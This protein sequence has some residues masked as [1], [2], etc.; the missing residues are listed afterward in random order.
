MPFLGHAILDAEMDSAGGPYPLAIFVHGL[1]GGTLS[2]IYLCEHLAS[3]GF[4]VIAIDYADSGDLSTQTDP[5][6]SLFTRPK[7]VS[8]QIDYMG[9]LNV[10]K[11][12]KL[13]GMIDLEHIALIGHSFGG[14]T[15]LVAGGALV[16]LTGPTSWCLKEPNKDLPAE[17]GGGTLQDRF[18]SHAQ[19]VANLADLK[20]VPDGL[21]PSWGDPRIDV[22]VSL[23]P[24]LPYFGAES[25][26]TIT[27]PT[28]LMYGTK[29]HI[30]WTEDTLYQP[31]AY[32]NLSSKTKSLV[33]FDQADHS[34]F[35]TD[36]SS[37][38]WL[39]D[40]GFFWACSDQV[41]DMDRAHD[42]INHFTTAY[43]LDQL[44]GDKEAAKALAPDAVSFPGIEYKAQGF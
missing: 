17:I 29:D 3:Q 18:C 12:S 22:L 44:K 14:Y 30:V 25:T 15:T 42:L 43:L 40:V 38:S 20:A 34:V 11:N 19:E 32:D 37:A 10:D 27:I 35:G 9:R 1:G 8:W 36:C 5:A 28:M 31:Y 4:I 39:A 16:D 24:W 2:S 33:L 41:W 13:Q 7:D 21:W 6:L 26:K 23:A